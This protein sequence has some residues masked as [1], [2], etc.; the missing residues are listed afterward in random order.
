MRSE[1][2]RPLLRS[3]RFRLG[4]RVGVVAVAVVLIA[5]APTFATSAN[6]FFW[7]VVGCWMLFATSV[8]LLL[9][10]ADMPSFGQAAYFGIG[11]YTVGMTFER[12]PV[13]AF[14]LLA[15]L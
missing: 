13:V 7:E 14:L 8:N 9:G 15:M 4:T 10:Y 3:A 1:A 11:A 5:V 6:L 2:A 12:L